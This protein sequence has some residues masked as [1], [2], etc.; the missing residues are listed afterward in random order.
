ML[1]IPAVPVLCN[2]LWATR[3]EAVQ[4]ARGDIALAFC[5]QCGHGWNT[6][7]DPSLMTYNQTYENSLHFSPTFQSYA[8]SLAKRLVEDYDIRNKDIIEIG[9]GQGDFL[10]SLCELGNNRG[11]GFDPSYNPDQENHQTSE[12]VSFVQDM[13]SEKYTDYPADVVCSRHVLEHI[14][15]PSTM[16]QNIRKAIETKSSTLLFFE[17]PNAL[18]MFHDLSIYDII[19]EHCSYF[20]PGSLSYVFAANGYHVEEVRE[21]FNGQFLS[22]VAN[23]SNTNQSATDS[24][25]WEGLA[26]MR[27]DIEVFA[28]HYRQKVN[29]WNEQLATFARKGEKAVVWGAGSK[30]I[31]FLNTLQ[32][33]DQ[34]EYVVDINPRKQG[35]Y[36]TGTGQEIV[37]P[38][39]LQT[40]QPDVVIIMNMAYQNEIRQT[41]KNLGIA[42]RCLEG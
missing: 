10:I 7:F 15:L 28:N 4:A 30:G 25:S 11:I 33:R 14:P 40:Y 12:R 6:I 42:A 2:V 41:L 9:S 39:F 27:A 17:V 1:E 21:E 24:S 37:P 5:P 16:L 23:S 29:E 36:I 18:F 32:N 8:Q 19:Y 26:Q 22:I 31:M 13:Y 20:S 38:E 3:E 35:K 34:I